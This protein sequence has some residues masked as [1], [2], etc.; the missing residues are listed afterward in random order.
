MKHK[1]HPK[2]ISPG[3]SIFTWRHFKK[4]KLILAMA[5]TF[6]V[7]LIEIIGGFLTNSLA[8]LS[9]AGHM[10]THFFSLLVSFF[11][12]IYASRDPCCHRTFGFYRIEILAALFNSVFLFFVSGWIIYEG[13]IRIFSPLN[14]LIKEMFSIAV[15]GLVA[16]LASAFILKESAKGDINIKGAFLHVLGDTFSSVAI[17]VGAGVIYFTGW[18]FIDPLL[19]VIIALLIFIWGWELFKDSINIL[20]EGTPKGINSEEVSS[21]IKETVPQIE[22]VVDLHIWEITSQMYSLTAHI[23]F[24][25]NLSKQEIKEHLKKIKKVLNERFDIEHTTIEVE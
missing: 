17:V 6:M 24:F 21:V 25:D 11:A 13:I 3:K 2:I 8:L 23:R 14:I 18:V 10:F 15:L 12:I 20:L 5:I 7:M 22:E 4:K 16:N 9:D 19:S 1:H